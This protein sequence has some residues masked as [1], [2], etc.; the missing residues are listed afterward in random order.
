M[1]FPRWHYGCPIPGD[2]QGQAEQNSEQPDQ[3]VDFPGLAGEL[4]QV[5]FKGPLQLKWF[6]GDSVTPYK[7]YKNKAVIGYLFCTWRTAQTA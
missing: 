2:S 5:T 7:G 4:Q 1:L 6:Y 3:A